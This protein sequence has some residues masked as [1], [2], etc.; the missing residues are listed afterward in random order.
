MTRDGLVTLEE[1]WAEVLKLDMVE[2]QTRALMGPSRDD[3]TRE[4]FRARGRVVEENSAES[5]F[6]QFARE[7]RTELDSAHSRARAIK[8]LHERIE[9]ITEYSVDER[10]T[11]FEN[12][13]IQRGRLVD[14]SHPNA[15]PQLDD[16]VAQRLGLAEWAAGMPSE[17]V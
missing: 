6:R 17:A 16:G 5:P 11:G 4:E 8:Q 14:P 9:A 1:S 12:T 15:R 13:F 2:E 10:T 3:E 7:L